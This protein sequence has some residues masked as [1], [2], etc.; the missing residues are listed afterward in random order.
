MSLKALSGFFATLV[1]AFCC[2][3]SWAQGFDMQQQQTMQPTLPNIGRPYDVRVT[4]GAHTNAG[5][6]KSLTDGDPNLRHWTWM[7]VTN[8][9]QAYIH[10][11]AGSAGPGKSAVQ[12]PA[13]VYVKPET[14]PLPINPAYSRPWKPVVIGNASNSG[15]SHAGGN[16]SGKLVVHTQPKSYTATRATLTKSYGGSYG[17]VGGKLLRPRMAVTESSAVS[18]R[19]LTH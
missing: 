5:W 16:V 13:H 7:P 11:P 8:Y 1:A 2:V 10:V 3:P 18:G 17:D 12:R 14:V 9:D 4:T 19:L 15:S 6:E